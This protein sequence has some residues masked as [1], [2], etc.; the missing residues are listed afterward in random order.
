MDDDDCLIFSF[1][2]GLF[3]FKIKTW[4]PP[5]TYRVNHSNSNTC[6]FKLKGRLYAVEKE[7][8]LQILFSTKMI[9]MFWVTSPLGER[10]AL[11][12]LAW[13]RSM[14]GR[15]ARDGEEG[16]R[17][18]WERLGHEPERL[19]CGQHRA[20]VKGAGRQRHGLQICQYSHGGSYMWFS[21]HVLNVFFLSVGVREKTEKREWERSVS[22]DHRLCGLFSQ[23]KIWIYLLKGMVWYNQVDI[24]SDRCYVLYHDSICMWVSDKNLM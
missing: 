8:L 15:R 1:L 21:L 10:G 22:G 16:V 23:V 5:K 9:C 12:D 4:G 11:I 13:F 7:L 3:S 17:G 20:R 14:L 19:R 24:T 18:R 6:G 2:I